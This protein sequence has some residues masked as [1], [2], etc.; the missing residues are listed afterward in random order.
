[1]K[2]QANSRH[3]FVCG[4]HNDNGL[5]IFFYDEEPGKVTASVTVPRHFQGYPGIVHGGVIAAMLDEVSGRT[6]MSGDDVSRW[7]VTASLSIRYRKPVPVEKPLKLVGTLKADNGII[8][9][10]HGEIQDE[11]GILLAEGDAVMANVP[12]TLQSSIDEL[13]SDDWQIYPDQEGL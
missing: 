1:M 3:C 6:M 13:T 4:V 8:V 10:A 5:K 7:M 11:N 12:K 2:K 9:R